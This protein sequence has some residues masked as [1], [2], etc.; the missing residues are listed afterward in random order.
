MSQSNRDVTTWVADLQ[1]P[2]GK[3]L[4]LLGLHSNAGTS[5]SYRVCRAALQTAVFSELTIS[6][7]CHPDG[8]VFPCPDG[9]E[10]SVLDAQFR[11]NRLSGMPLDSLIENALVLLINEPSD[12]ARRQLQALR[13][14]LARGLAAVDDRLGRLGE[15]GGIVSH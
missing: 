1:T 4:S 14:K 15:C 11:E 10:E 9:L 2:P 3:S 13:L 6:I 7:L 8:V 12:E 5:E